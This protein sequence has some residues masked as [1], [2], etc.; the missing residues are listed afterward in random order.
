MLFTRL[1]ITK[2]KLGAIMHNSRSNRHLKL[3]ATIITIV[4]LLSHMGINCFALFDRN[5]RLHNASVISGRVYSIKSFMDSRCID[6]VNGLTANGSNVWTYPYNGAACQEWQIV[7]IPNTTNEYMIKDMNSGKYLSIEDNSPNEGANGWIWY[8]DGSTGQ[9]FQIVNHAGVYYKFLT[10]CSNY[11]KALAV[12]Y[13]THNIYQ[14]DASS[15]YALFYLEDASAKY[16]IPEGKGYL[17]SEDTLRFLRKSTSFWTQNKIVQSNIDSDIISDGLFF[18][19]LG[20]GYYRIDVSSNKC[21]SVKNNNVSSGLQAS[22]Y[23]GATGQQWKATIAGESITLSPKCNTGYYL[24]IDASNNGHNKELIVSNNVSN[25]RFWLFYSA[26]CI[27]D[28]TD[29]ADISF[30]DY[31]HVGCAGHLDQVDSSVKCYSGAL[32]D[33]KSVFIGYNDGTSMSVL[34]FN[35]V[36]TK[37]EFLTVHTHG[38]LE[39]SAPFAPYINLNSIDVSGAFTNTQV[40]YSYDDLPDMDNCICAHFLCCHSGEGLYINNNAANFLTYAVDQ[41]GVSY[42]IGYDGTVECDYGEAFLRR[43]NDFLDLGDSIYS[44]I[45]DA[46]DAMKD[47]EEI[48]INQNKLV[49]ITAYRIITIDPLTGNRI[50]NYR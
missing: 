9:I 19:Y 34:D 49:V 6:V 45:I 40:K 26:E 41:C 14:T 37:A 10:K 31:S 38:G 25:S 16:G 23:S 7:Q 18:T 50:H 2:M 39:N 28:V 47:D 3:L 24:S 13:S 32:S 33:M 35:S 21:L 48:V 29:Y 8:D 42:A 20:A 17:Q 44:A 4:L 27:S 36:A 46:I 11:T 1:K 22:A 5:G 12:N 15:A 43:F 30:S